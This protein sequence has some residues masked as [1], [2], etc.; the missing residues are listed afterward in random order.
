MKSV[1]DAIGTLTTDFK[2]GF[3][4]KKCTGCVFLDIEGAFDNVD[5]Y[6]LCKLLIRLK[7]PKSFVKLIFNLMQLK[8]II[9][10]NVGKII[11]TDFGQVR[12]SNTVRNKIA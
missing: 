12:E 6:L 4:E 9:G 5:I 3:N 2:S 7:F 1:T 8:K 11:G 10:Y